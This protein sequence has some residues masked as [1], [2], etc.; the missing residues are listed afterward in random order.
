[1]IEVIPSINEE[2]W[3]RVQAA[4]R[5]VDG[6]TDWVEIDVCDGSLSSRKT[7]NV[8]ADLKRME[9]NSQLHVAAHLMMRDP[10]RFVADWIRAGVRRVVV[11]WEG[12]R[13]RGLRALFPAAYRAEVVKRIAGLCRENWV[14]FGISIGLQTGVGDI[15]QLLP[16]C[17]VVQVLAVPVGESGKGFSQADVDK[18]VMLKEQRR[19]MQ[20]KIAW[21][22]GVNLDTIE[23]LAHAGVDIAASTSFVFG[24]S[25]PSRALEA[26][27]RRVTGI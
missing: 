21:D 27:R 9:A 6:A 11:Q 1:M 22:G 8:P 16:T 3:E 24:A 4:V 20:Y 12:I 15:Q 14:E 19:S 13:A 10:Q 18:A 23:L 25:N 5:A 7:W 2:T 26:L 17:D